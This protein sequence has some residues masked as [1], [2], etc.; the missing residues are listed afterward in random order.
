MSE[1]L[2]FYPTLNE[3]QFVNIGYTTDI[4]K[5]S[6]TENYE[7]FPLSLENI[8]ENTRNF[9]WK[10]KG[11]HFALVWPVQTQENLEIKEQYPFDN[12]QTAF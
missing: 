10:L 5:F 6:Y 11:M 4:P 12:N 8:T 9:N 1:A 7:E 2:N 3:S